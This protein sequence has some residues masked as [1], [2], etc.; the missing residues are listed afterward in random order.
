[1]RRLAFADPGVA[2][3]MVF[4]LPMPTFEQ[5]LAQPADHVVVFRVDHDQ[6]SVAP[7]NGENVEHLE[8]VELEQVVGHV[9][10]ERRETS[11]DQGRQFLPEDMR[12]RIRDD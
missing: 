7:G 2:D 10:L 12:G 8:V 6:R 1:M 4:R 3:R 5:A 11:L 9:D